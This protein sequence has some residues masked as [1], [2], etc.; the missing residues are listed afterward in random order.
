MKLLLFLLMLPL[1]GL[2]GAQPLFLNPPAGDALW[3]M[4]GDSLEYQ[5]LDLNGTWAWQDPHSA[6]KGQVQVPG[7]FLGE[8][9]E[10]V[11]TREFSLPAAGASRESSLWFGGMNHT[12]RITLNGEF[13][14]SHANGSTS[15]EL[16]VPE[17]LLTRSGPNRLQIHVDRRLSS[18]ISLPLKVQS[19]D[20]CNFGGIFREVYLLQRPRVRVE[21]LRWSLLAGADPQVE[22][23]A[24]LRNL[25]LV[26][27]GQDSLARTSELTLVARLLTPEGLE[28][29]HAVQPGVLRRQESQTHQLA[30]A[31]GG[32]P[33]WSPD[34][35]RLVVIEAGLYEGER[36][37]HRIRR[38]TG[39]RD[40]QVQ[41]GRFLLNGAE[42][43]VKGVRYVPEHPA[44]GSALSQAQLTRDMETIKNLGANLVLVAGG[45][46]HPGLMEICNRL[47]LFVIGELPAMQVPPALLAAEGFLP[48]A[49]NYL[50]EMVIR[51]RN[52]PCLFAISAGHGLDTADGRTL[53]FLTG[54]LETAR[55]EPRLLLTAGVLHPLTPRD[56][57]LDFLLLEDR[58]AQ[59]P[60]DPGIPLVLSH[61]GLPVEVDNQDGYANPF[62]SL[63]QA[64]HIQLRLLELRD[65]PDLDGAVIDG[66]ADWRGGRPLLWVPPGEDAYRVPRGILSAD[67][68]AR[69][70]FNEVRSLFGNG[71]GTALTRGEYS[72]ERPLDYPMAG[73]LLLILLLVGLKQ[74]KVFAQNLKRSFVHSHGFFSDVQDNRVYQFGQ[75]LFIGLLLSGACGVL[76][77]S[78]LY[79][80]RKSLLVDHLL[81]QILVLD[82]LKEWVAALAWQPVVSMLTLGAAAM[83]LGV[84]ATLGLRIMGLLFNARFS[85]GQ[86]FTF[87]TFAC[88]PM[89]FYIVLGSLAYRLLQIPSLLLP[90]LATAVI[91]PLWSLGRLLRSMRIA[92]GG[93]FLWAGLLMSVLV[94]VV[95]ALVFAYYE[96]SNSLMEYW[97]Y[98][99]A[100]YGGGA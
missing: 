74:N 64:R 71:T 75:S 22:V 72:P 12:C 44:S 14:G 80:L 3:P 88:A 42:F 32:A 60:A 56:S 20:P 5:A 23:G 97:N 10:L 1:G 24:V 45:S 86:A 29:S 6:G 89:L 26:R 35:P 90:T 98:Y 94:S 41:G 46:A 38:V 78:L 70:S 48:L 66:F 18:K 31:A 99:R 55:R 4:Q 25:E 40:L 15:F 73:F 28:I 67:R 92:F 21:E 51:D 30:L 8:A 63:R 100:V 39:L 52:E 36:L 13:L 79:D 65:R 81:G 19:W 95:A 43:Q 62:S 2:L 76:F 57:G 93:G 61:I 34:S 83:A 77:S 53:D 7:C 17:Q 47:G 9:D 11:F 58:R 33:L 37:V 59:L 16:P 96:N 82:E 91:L 85:L 54:L 27:I 50:Q 68:V 49:Q 69:A 87:I 84:L